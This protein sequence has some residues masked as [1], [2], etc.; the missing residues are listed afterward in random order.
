MDFPKVFKTLCSSELHQF[1]VRLA[2]QRQL[3]PVENIYIN[4]PRLLGTVSP[5]SS[6]LQSELLKISGFNIT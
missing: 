1:K 3:V 6:W 2:K 4:K 5:S